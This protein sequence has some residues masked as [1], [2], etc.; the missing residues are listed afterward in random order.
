MPLKIQQLLFLLLAAV[1]GGVFTFITAGKDLLRGK[2]E[3]DFLMLFAAIGA[4][5]LGKWGESALL[6]FLFSL[7]HALEHYAMRRARKSIAALSDLAPPMALVKHNGE[8]IEVHI[9]QLRI[10]DII[11]VKP[12]SKI[13]ADGVVTK[14][15]SPVNQASITGESIPVDKRPSLN[16]QNENE[17][18]KFAS[19]ASGFCGYNEWQWC[20]GN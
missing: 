8:L 1:F 6:L 4:A 18:K 17:I 13:A 9:E 10:G 12:N 5:A 20:A 3:I 15:I 2:F 11:V 7:G 14:G 19:G 16:W